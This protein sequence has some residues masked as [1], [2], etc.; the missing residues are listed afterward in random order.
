MPR[1]LPWEQDPVPRERL[2]TIPEPT[3]HHGLSVLLRAVLLSS[4]RPALGGDI[5]SRIKQMSH[6]YTVDM[7]KD[8]LLSCRFLRELKQLDLSG[9]GTGED[10]G[11]ETLITPKSRVF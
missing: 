3:V 11:T 2:E 9:T 1:G 6:T 10:V 7:V 8:E 4:A 5:R